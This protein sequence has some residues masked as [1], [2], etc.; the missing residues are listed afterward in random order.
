VVVKERVIK[1]VCVGG[2]VT[3]E[4]PFA[5][6]VAILL[7]FGATDRYCARF[8]GDGVRNDPT[9]TRKRNAP[10]PGACP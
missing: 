4:P 3:P 8:G 2:G 7:S 10:A 5:G 9:M 1:A 6:D